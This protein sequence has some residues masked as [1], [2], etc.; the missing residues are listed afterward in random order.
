MF[1]DDFEAQVRERM[2]QAEILKERL[3]LIAGE[4][5]SPDHSV[6]VRVGPG[7]VPMALTIRDRA[8]DLGGPRLAELIL[9][10]FREAG[11][12]AGELARQA[13]AETIGEPIRLED[14]LGG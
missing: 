10:G 6:S 8:L 12:R 2:A 5:T 13:A 14:L 9:Q 4:W 1:P 11:Q 3:K 7:G